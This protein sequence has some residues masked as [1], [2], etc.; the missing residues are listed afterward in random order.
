MLRKLFLTLFLVVFSGVAASAEL[1]MPN[2]K[3]TLGKNV[4]DVRLMGSD[5]S[6]FSLK[7]RMRGKPLILSLIY[8]KCTTTCLL[9]TDS[10]SDVVGKIGGL[11]EKYN[12]LTLSFDPADIN[13]KRLDEFRKTWRLEREGWIVAGGE[14]EEVDK[15][16]TAIDFGYIFDKAT[17]EFLHPNLLVILTPDGRVSRYFYG[18]TYNDKDLKLSLLEARKGIS[19]LSIAEGFLLRCFLFDPATMTYKT[20]WAFIMHIFGGVSFF[21][22]VF[23]VLKGKKTLLSIRRLSTRFFS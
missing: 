23:I 7:E 15:L 9:I 19:K 3:K 20:D 10:I 22:S 11:G 16:L 4:P 8:T 13:P 6:S 1:T 17:G 18:V 5:G 14:K 12:V 2:E 21:L